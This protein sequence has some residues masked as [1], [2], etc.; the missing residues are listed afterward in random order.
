MT[1]KCINRV[2]RDRNRERGREIGKGASEKVSTGEFGRKRKLELDR[3]R[4]A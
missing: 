4:T 3:N 1:K 2:K